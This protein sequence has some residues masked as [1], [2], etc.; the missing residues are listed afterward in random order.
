MARPRHLEEGKVPRKVVAPPPLA[1]AQRTP[2]G[3]KLPGRS[4]DRDPAPD[5]WTEVIDGL[6]PTED[7]A[8]TLVAQVTTSDAANL[9]IDRLHQHEDVQGAVRIFGDSDFRVFARRISLTRELF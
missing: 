4:P 6:K 2:A 8:W 3:S 1:R 5:D 7:A 9:V